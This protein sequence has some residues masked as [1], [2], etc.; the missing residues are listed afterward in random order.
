MTISKRGPRSK[1]QRRLAFNGWTRPLP[2]LLVLLA[3]AAGCGTSES[4]ENGQ[5]DDPSEQETIA[6]AGADDGDTSDEDTSNSDAPPLFELIE[7]ESDD[8][9]QKASAVVYGQQPTEQMD[10]L[11]E[12]ALTLNEG[13]LGVSSKFD[14]SFTAV[15]WPAGSSLE[16]DEDGVVLLDDRGDVVAHEGD[17]ISMG[18]G[19]SPD[20]DGEI[21]DVAP[22]ECTAESYWMSGSEV[23]LLE[24]REVGSS[25]NDPA[26]PDATPHV[27]TE[28]EAMESDAQ[29]YADAFGI[30][31]DEAIR[32]LELQG[33]LLDQP[34]ALEQNEADRFGGIFWEHEP[35]YRL[36]VM[37]TDG[38]EEAVREYFDDPD[39]L[40]I[41]EVREVEYTQDEL[42]ET[43]REYTELLHELG[44][45]VSSST[46][47]QDN[48]VEIYHA[49]PSIVEDALASAGE[50]LPE[51]VVI[52]ESEEVDEEAG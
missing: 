52:I 42:R 5:G 28:Q 12:G 6:I 34:L 9:E 19:N 18:G 35:E 30:E 20:P 26:D 43:Q 46:M 7:A 1:P 13:C 41:L 24:E 32:R 25:Q 44:I 40:E 48:R 11:M 49:D 15:V 31:L 17:D 21:A 47:I 38:D 50:E 29:H 39:L 33:R 16:F 8:G 22:E 3:L 36:V 27:Q 14:D 23:Q 37:M 45:R 51:H 4:A 10:A 2:F